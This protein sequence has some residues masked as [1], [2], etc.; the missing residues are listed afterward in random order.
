[1]TRRILIS[2]DHGLALVYFLQSD[3]L[4]TLLDHG[5]QVLVLT[6]DSLVPVLE[7]R[8][9]QPG[10]RFAGLRLDQARRYFHTVHYRYQYWLDFLRRAGASRRIPLGAVESFIQQVLFEAHPRRRR[11]LRLMLAYVALMR[12]F[13][14]A[15]QWVVRAQWRFT[16]SLYRDIFESFRPHLVVAST[17]GWRLDRYL[18]REAALRHRIP[19][20]AVIVGWDNTSSYSLPGAPVD[21]LNVW[22]AIQRQEAVLGAD[23]DPQ[24]IHIGGIPIYDG[25]FRRQWVLPREE[26]FRRHGLDPNRKLIAYASTFITFSPNFQNIEALARLVAHDRLASP[27]QLLIRL[28]PNHFLDVP[29]FAAERE[30]IFRLA[31][32]LPHVHVVK[33]VPL[34][35]SLGYYSGED[36]DEKS[37][38]MAHADVFTTV[39]STMVVETAIHDTP[40][41][42]VCIDAPEPWPGK[43]T[44]RLSQI[45]HWPTHSRFL[46]SG[47]G[48]VVH[49]A[50]QLRDALNRALEQP[51]A[52][53]EARQ[54]FVEQECTY[55]DGSAGQRTGHFLVQLAG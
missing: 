29:H 24:R 25:Y 30:R 21:Y 53:R 55:T 31:Q 20:A 40:I 44:L 35:G 34:G 11:W 36:M 54:R 1:M 47:A 22:S 27:A 14:A 39:Y 12:R 18:L 50:G 6:D 32:E 15:R 5:A 52:R 7:E 28:H 3:V 37:S 17:P 16:P 4:P 51:H 13:R 19:T 45:D 8:F 10:V 23:W 2:A 9:G 42:S 26:Y 38:M 41:V 33:P 46:R 48:E 43:F 49:D